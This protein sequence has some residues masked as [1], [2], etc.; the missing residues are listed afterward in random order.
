MKLCTEYVIH[1]LGKT[2]REVNT[3][4]NF[5]QLSAKK[6]KETSP[7]IVEFARQNTFQVVGDDDDNDNDFN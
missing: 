4:Q 2:R 3:T 1:D 7:L 6:A 5:G